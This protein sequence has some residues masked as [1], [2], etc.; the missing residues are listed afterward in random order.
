MQRAEESRE[1]TPRRYIYTQ[2]LEC[3]LQWTTLLHKNH[4]TPNHQE[5][6]LKDEEDGVQ[7]SS[8]GWH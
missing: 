6:Y 4:S 8:R 2:E 1:R 5:F 7:H 3:T